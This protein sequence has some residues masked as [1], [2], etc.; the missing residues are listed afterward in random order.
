MRFLVAAAALGGCSFTHGVASAPGDGGGDDGDIDAEISI[1]AALGPWGTPT[2]LAVPAPT[3]TD[4]DASLT[5]DQLEL[6][7]NSARGGNSDVYVSVRATTQDAW[8]APTLVMDVST[9]A[10]ETTPEIS[11]DGLTMVLASNRGGSDSGSQDLYVATR[12]SRTGRWTNPAR[13]TELNA[14]SE[15]SAGNMT[16]DGTAIVFSS[17]RINGGTDL[18]IATR[19]SGSDP[20]D[21][22]VEIT[23]VNAIGHEGSPFLTADKLTLY[24]DTDR[25]G[26]LDIYTSHRAS[27]ADP[28]PPPTPI[29]ELQTPASEEDPWVSPDGHQLVFTSNAGGVL[30]LWESRR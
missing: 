25:D 15:E 27:I 13:I 18:F 28:F 14:P 5:A 11:Y 4:D 10:V 21:P 3:N 8:P 24:F 7:I 1:D 17:T 9:N 22:P 19:T 30:Q 16:P 2:V 20:W 6:F 12:P 26:S 29:A 23:A